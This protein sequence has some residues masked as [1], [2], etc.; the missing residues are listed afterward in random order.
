[1]LFWSPPYIQCLKDF[2]PKPCGRSEVSDA[3]VQEERDD[4]YFK[5]EDW[6]PENVDAHLE[7]EWV[8]RG[9]QKSWPSNQCDCSSLHCINMHNTVHCSQGDLHLKCPAVEI[10]FI[11]RGL[12]VSATSS[13]FYYGTQCRSPPDI[14]LSRTSLYLFPCACLIS[15]QESR[16]HSCNVHPQGMVYWY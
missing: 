15:P 7:R 12:C 13:W 11:L 10:L 14:H 2:F 1:M 8:G 3:K 16:L 4:S 6:G 9:A 5:W